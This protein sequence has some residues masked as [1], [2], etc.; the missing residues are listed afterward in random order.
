[1]I[2]APILDR[3]D[4]PHAVV[5]LSRAESAAVARVLDEVYRERM[6][7]AARN[8]ADAPSVLLSNLFQLS[9]LVQAF[10]RR[11]E[12]LP[13]NPMGTDVLHDV[14]GTV[15]SHREDA[16]PALRSAWEKIHEEWRCAVGIDVL[17]GADVT[18]RECG[19]E[20][21]NGG[22][23]VHWER[24]HASCSAQPDARCTACGA[25][26]DPDHDHFETILTEGRVEQ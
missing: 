18:C 11:G 6:N 26:I 2:D 4:E 25:R 21:L 15:N 12:E 8:P 9:N 1:M 24:P 10:D 7:F 13:L 3:R 16:C 22:A 14:I 5:D 17:D 20:L 19:H 23:R